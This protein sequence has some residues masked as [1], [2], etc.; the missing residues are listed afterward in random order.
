[1][2]YIR[3]RLTLA[4]YAYLTLIPLYYNSEILSLSYDGL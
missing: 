1:M 3:E 4:F 2:V